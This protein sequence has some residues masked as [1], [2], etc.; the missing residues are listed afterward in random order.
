MQPGPLLPEQRKHSRGH[1]AKT[2]DS[3]GE[4][5]ALHL[6]TSRW[7]VRFVRG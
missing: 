7:L 3:T 2:H 1:D 6:R 4:I 5:D